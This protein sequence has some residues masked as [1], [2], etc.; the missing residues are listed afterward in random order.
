MKM[1]PM[2]FAQGHHELMHGRMD[3]VLLV[4]VTEVMD[5]PPMRLGQFHVVLLR[6]LECYLFSEL[7]TPVLGVE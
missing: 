7:F 4:I 3:L 1:L 6:L 5:Q 2:V